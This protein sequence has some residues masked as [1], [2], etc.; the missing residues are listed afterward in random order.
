MCDD[1]NCQE[2]IPAITDLFQ[3]PVD[4][5]TMKTDAAEIEV[6]KYRNLK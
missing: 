3:T 2:V 4:R 5:S 6:K 1:K